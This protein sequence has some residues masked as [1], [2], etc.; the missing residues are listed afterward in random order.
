MV[1][2]QGTISAPP[3]F[4][5]KLVHFTLVTLNRKR[6][7][8]KWMQ[9]L[10]G[11]WIRMMQYRRESMGCFDK[12]WFHLCRWR[13]RK[14]LPSEVRV[15]LLLELC[16]LPIMR[17]DLRLPVSGM[18]TVSDASEKMGAVVR[19]VR[20]TGTGRAALA[21]QR[22]SADQEHAESV[23]LLSLFDGIGG[24]MRAM[25]LIG[26]PVGLFISAEV[27][28][29][30]MRVVRYVWPD[31]LEAGDVRK[32]SLKEVRAWAQRSPSCI[33][34]QWRPIGQSS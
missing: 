9:I 20:L 24:A 15:G 17:A 27:D 21:A 26:V 34:S 30:A 4:V 33:R 8:Q 10:A 28:P 16:L 2:A 32:L 23:V 19:A 12:L 18:V 13:G 22:C 31:V 6:V 14:E 11:R 25:E 7:S 3:D 1:G 5:K 29:E